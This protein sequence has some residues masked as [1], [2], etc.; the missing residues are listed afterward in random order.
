MKLYGEELRAS[1]LETKKIMQARIDDRINR[2]N[3]CE[4]DMDE[5]FISQH[6]EE[7]AIRECN[8]QLEILDGDGCW[9]WNVFVDENGKE[10]RVHCFTNK[11]GGDSYVANGV[12]A[13]S[14]K[15]LMKKTG[16]KETTIRVPVWTKFV[17][18]GSG[19]CGVYGGSTQ[20]V[21]WHTNMVTGEYVGYPD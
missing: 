1:I 7:D 8:M 5:C 9:D 21:R 10:V 6:I 19:M 15:A 11:W 17:S 16:I 14:I 2:I 12:F 20:V 4:T 13:S 3:N 18:S